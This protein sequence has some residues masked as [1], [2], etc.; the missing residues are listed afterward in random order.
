VQGELDGGGGVRP[1]REG[2]GGL[3]SSREA[4]QGSSTSSGAPAGCCVVDEAPATNSRRGRKR[5]AGSAVGEGELVGAD[6]QFIEEREGERAPGGRRN[7]RHN[8]IDGIHGGFEWREREGETRGGVEVSAV[9]L[10][11]HGRARS[12]R[13]TRAMFW[14][15]RGWGRRRGAA[16]GGTRSAG[17]EGGGRKPSPD[18]DFTVGP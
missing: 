18:G 15:R 5:M 3:A 7:D 11:G 9:R 16:A 13:S 14:W 12:A 8:S 10:R 17:R 2:T 4:G 1:G 6:V